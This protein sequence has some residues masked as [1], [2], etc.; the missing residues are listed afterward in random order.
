MGEKIRGGIMAT[1][2][3]MKLAYQDLEIELE[4][5]I[6]EL[7]VENEELRKALLEKNGTK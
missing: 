3:D 2:Q 5:K 6:C 7:K 4:R 1:D